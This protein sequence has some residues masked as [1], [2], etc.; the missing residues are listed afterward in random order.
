[1]CRRDG[2]G[3]GKENRDRTSNRRISE[4]GKLCCQRGSMLPKKTYELLTQNIS[5]VGLLLVVSS[6]RTCTADI[7]ITQI[8]LLV[9]MMS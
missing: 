3:M 1:M 2:S 9:A 8:C 6:F 4:T 5:V 7:T